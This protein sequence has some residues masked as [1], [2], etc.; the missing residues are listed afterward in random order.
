MGAMA[1]T[2]VADVD[3]VSTTGDGD[4]SAADTGERFVVHVDSQ[5]Y[6]LKELDMKGFIASEF[7]G[8]LAD[9]QWADVKIDI[10]NELGSIEMRTRVKVRTRSGSKTFVGLW[11]WGAM[12]LEGQVALTDYLIAKKQRRAKGPKTGKA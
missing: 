3:N 7:D 5:V 1:G 11:A 12:P 4:A 9:K 2:V 10:N 6:P 8:A